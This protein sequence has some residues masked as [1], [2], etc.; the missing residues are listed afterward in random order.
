ML[1][2][3]GARA[4]TQLQKIFKLAERHAMCHTFWGKVDMVP[5]HKKG[6]DEQTWTA[7]DP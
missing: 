2:H 1:V 7:S 3:L 6:K 5:I 4:K